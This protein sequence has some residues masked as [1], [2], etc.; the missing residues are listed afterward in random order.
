MYRYVCTVIYVE[1]SLYRY[2][3]ASTY[4]NT[5]LNAVRTALA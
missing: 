2:I 4:V 1:I 3:T 5:W